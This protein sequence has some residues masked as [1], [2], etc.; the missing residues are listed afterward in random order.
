MQTYGYFYGLENSN[1]LYKIYVTEGSL[2][3]AKV[4]GSIYDEATARQITYHFGLLGMLF[5]K[6]VAASYIRK[7]QEKEKEYDQMEPG[8][9]SFLNADKVNFSLG[10]GGITRAVVNHKRSGLKNILQSSPA[11]ELH[12][13]DGKKR[14]FVLIGDQSADYVRNLIVRVIP[15][16]EIVE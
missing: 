6:K 13:T 12:L 5:H 10:S 16:V 8:S 4:A 11:V 3:G 15:N 9:Q 1:G 14:R 7:R 2:C